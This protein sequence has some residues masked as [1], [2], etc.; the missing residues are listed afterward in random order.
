MESKYGTIGEPPVVNRFTLSHERISQRHKVP[1]GRTRPE[2]FQVRSDG[3]V[4]ATSSEIFM[5]LIGQ[6]GLRVQFLE[7]PFVEFSGDGF[8]DI[9]GG[10]GVLPERLFFLHGFEA[11][12]SSRAGE[13]IHTVSRPNRNHDMDLRCVEPH[14]AGIPGNEVIGTLKIFAPFLTQA[15]NQGDS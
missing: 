3:A 11:G 14:S 9:V 6:V 8:I 15:R 4:L 2:V 5:L 12:D 7:V 10:H 1:N 13:D